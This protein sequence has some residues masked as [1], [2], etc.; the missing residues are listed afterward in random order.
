MW[1]VDDWYDYIR[2]VTVIVSTVCVVILAQRYF[3]N[4][5]NWNVKTTD[6]WYAL[7]AW[8]VSGVAIPIESMIRDSPPSARP[9]FL[10]V[11]SLVT[12]KGLLH[13][14]S[15]GDINT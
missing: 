11:A 10:L 14:G 8:C 6:Y 15:W 4:G 7:T 9:V 12:L 5:S 3:T 1:I 2:L 13:K